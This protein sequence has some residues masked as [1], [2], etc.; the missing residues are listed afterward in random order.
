MQAQ[1]GTSEM[2]RALQIEI[3]ARDGFDAREIGRELGMKRH[4]VQRI[5]RRWRIAL[6]GAGG[7]R[8]PCVGISRR[9][10]AMVGRL[11]SRA[12]VSRS[13]MMGRLIVVALDGG[14]EAVARRLGKLGTRRKAYRPRRDR[15]EGR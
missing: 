8:F 3:L 10:Y 15:G 14:D 9:P 7:R 6:A 2:E 5:A 4:R 11:A 12:G 13:V 1:P